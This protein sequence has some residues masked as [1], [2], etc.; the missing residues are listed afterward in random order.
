MWNQFGNLL[1]QY[2]T[3]TATRDKLCSKK[4]SGHVS[5]DFPSV[6]ILLWECP[7]SPTGLVQGFGEPGIRSPLSIP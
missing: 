6:V 5:Y 3:R 7:R 4:S 2:G 1:F